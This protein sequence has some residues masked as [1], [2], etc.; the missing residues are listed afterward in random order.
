LDANRLS[1]FIMPF[2]P[3]PIGVTSDHASVNARP[4]SIEIA[5]WPV[6]KPRAIP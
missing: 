4:N 5:R 3:V 2:A 1:G 6:T